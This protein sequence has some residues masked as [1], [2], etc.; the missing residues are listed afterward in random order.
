MGTWIKEN[1]SF[2]D[3]QRIISRLLERV[4]VFSGLTQQ[5]L[6][7][8]LEA[9]GK[10]IFKEGEAIVQEGRSGSFLYVI[11]EGRVKVIKSTPAGN[12]ELASLQAGDSFG[13]MSL[14]DQ[15]ARSASVIASSPCVLLRL[16]ENDCSRHP[17]SSTKI[18]RNL[19]RILSQRLRDMDD[20]FVLGRVKPR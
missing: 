13:E 8:L 16:S 2:Q 20:A 17:A 5:E 7:D 1:L 18:Y 6:L 19:A 4:E 11:I 9:A 14:V 12:K 15:Q 10:C 3:L